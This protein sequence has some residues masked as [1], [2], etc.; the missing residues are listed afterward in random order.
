MPKSPILTPEQFVQQVESAWSQS[1]LSE[2]K[3]LLEQ[4]VSGLAALLPKTCFLVS[5]LLGGFS[6]F[7]QLTSRR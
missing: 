7:Q 3:Q 1:T 4:K 5:L 6:I 2:R